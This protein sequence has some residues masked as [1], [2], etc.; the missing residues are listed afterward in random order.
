MTW[1]WGS[2]TRSPAR[3][4]SLFSKGTLPPRY[5]VC[6]HTRGVFEGQPVFIEASDVL[7]VTEFEQE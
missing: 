3:L 6:T 1:T 5:Y 7:S 2:P 4:L